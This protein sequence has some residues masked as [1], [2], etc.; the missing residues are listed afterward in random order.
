MCLGSSPKR[1]EWSHPELVHG[2]LLVH[3]SPDSEQANR[4]VT[5]ICPEPINRFIT[6]IG[7][8]LANRFVTLICTLEV[9]FVFLAVLLRCN[10]HIRVLFCFSIEAYLHHIVCLSRHPFG[11]MFEGK[12][13][14]AGG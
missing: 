1:L 10:A 5:L 11:G 4:F 13:R 8:E 7:P 2:W 14:A 9:F 6:L 12:Y 3:S